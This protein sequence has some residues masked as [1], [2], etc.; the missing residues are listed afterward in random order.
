METPLLFLVFNR[1]EI[2]RQTFARIRNV[3]P[4]H[5]F[6]AG[7]GPRPQVSADGARCQ[8]VRDIVGN[9]DWKCS[10]QYLLREKNLGCGK[11]VS[12]AID[13]FFEHVSRGIILEDDC[14]PSFDF[15]SYMEEV[16]ERHSGDDRVMTVSGCSLQNGERRTRYSYFF[17]RYCHL[18]GWGTWKTA[19]K[20]YDFDMKSYARFKADAGLE[21]IFGDAHQAAFWYGIFDKMSRK[22]IDTWDYQWIYAMLSNDGLSAYPEANMVTNIGFGAEATHTRNENHPFSMV[23]AGSIGALSHPEFVFPNREAD[24]FTARNVFRIGR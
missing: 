12:S 13:W 1:P 9:V 22:E 8:Q 21:N 18:W 5:L 17:S 16:L 4:R 2:T 20:K 23:P 7:D 11:A 19:W 14:Y 3:Q 15:F 6:I 10:V 24:G